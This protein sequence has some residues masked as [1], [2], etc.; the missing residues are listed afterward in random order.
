MGFFLTAPEA[1]IFEGLF[2]LTWETIPTHLGY[3]LGVPWLG[4]EFLEDLTTKLKNR[5]PPTRRI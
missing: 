5:L 2:S 4:A 1:Q 3:H